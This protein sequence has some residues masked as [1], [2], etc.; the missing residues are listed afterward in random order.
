MN[1]FNT[2]RNGVEVKIVETG[3]TFNSIQACAEYLSASVSQ[4]G[5]VCRGVKGSCTV[6]GYHIV[7]TDDTEP[8]I[9]IYRNEYRGRPGVRVQIVETGEVFESLTD[10]AKAIDG[11]PNRVHDV[12]YGNRKTHRGYHFKFID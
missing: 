1:N 3:E 5:R 9:D 4:V 12:I 10:C 8:R 11:Y 7:R 6:H 2:K